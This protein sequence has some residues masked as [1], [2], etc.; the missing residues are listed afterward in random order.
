MNRNLHPELMDWAID[1]FPLCAC[2]VSPMHP[3][4]EQMMGDGK[5]MRPGEA[6]R[7]LPFDH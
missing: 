2:I 6:V 1:G 4:S 3:A 7:M 5:G